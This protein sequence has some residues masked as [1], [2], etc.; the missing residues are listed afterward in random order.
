VAFDIFMIAYG[1]PNAAE[2]WARLKSIAPNARLIEGVAGVYAAYAAC[3]AAAGTPWFFSV[4][5]DN[6]VTEGFAF[7]I[8]FEPRHD[9]IAS[10]SATNQFNQLRYG[11]GAIKLQPTE[12]FHADAVGANTLDHVIEMAPRQRFV[13]VCA[14]EHRFATSP[15]ATWSTVFRECVKMVI[16]STKGTFKHRNLARHRLELWT[17]PDPAA[18]FADWCRRGAEEGG[19]YAHEHYRDRAAIHLVNDYAWMHAQFRERHVR[20]IAIPQPPKQG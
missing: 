18:P 16:L 1:E 11:H 6:W 15:Y 9:E 20:K 14:S 13:P 4:D 17:K 10:W 12:L 19:R 7:E 8:P 5:A 2:N 3:A